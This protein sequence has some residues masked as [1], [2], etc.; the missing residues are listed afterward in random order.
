MNPQPLVLAAV[1]AGALAA[2]VIDLRTRRVPNALTASIAC[3]GLAL[4]ASGF[5]RVDVASSL[6]GALA[7]LAFML[8]G[9]LFG[10]TGAG[11]VKLLAAFG[12]LLGPSATLAAFVATA[13]AG[14]L[15][16]LAVTA[17]RLRRQHTLGDRY[18]AYAPAIAA[19][20]SFAAFGGF[21]L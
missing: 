5:G 4:A 3:V 10:R 18:F 12:T 14:G 9:Y 13:I 17:W 8:P 16:A 1:A 19:G 2:A 15:L 6:G 7:G 21:A 20:V 11:D